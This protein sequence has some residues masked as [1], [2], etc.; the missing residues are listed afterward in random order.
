MVKSD[1]VPFFQACATGSLENRSL[2]I[3]A[4]CAVDVVLTSGGYPDEYHKNFEILGLDQ[5]DNTLLF[6]AGTKE[7]D[8]KIITS[9]G[10]VLN[11]VSLG[12]TFEECMENVYGEIE[13]ISFE[14]M[15]F[16]RDIGFQVLDK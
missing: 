11:L 8:G 16:R 9:G 15:Y 14:K 6:H 13:K 2:E 5:I 4:K 7:D 1:L 3:E 12:D 10:R